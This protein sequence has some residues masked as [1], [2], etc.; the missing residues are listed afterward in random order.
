MGT[1]KKN[2]GKRNKSKRK[3]LFIFKYL[4]LASL[5][6]SI[7]LFYV[8]ERVELL[9]AGYNIREK[10]GRKEK[11]MQEREILL[12]RAARF[13]SPQRLERI[14][15]EEIGLIFPNEVRVILW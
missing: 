10:E 1:R 15:R 4:L 11:L 14:A 6:L 9:E 8:W 12:L 3:N 2:K 13:K 5:C 7:V